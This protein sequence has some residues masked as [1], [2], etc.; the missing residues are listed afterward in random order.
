MT[1]EI[2]CTL[3][4]AE[5]SRRER[6]TRA[7]VER[8]LGTAERTREGVRIRLRDD[9]GVAEEVEELVARE[10]Q[11]CGFLEFAVE[12]R[13]GEVVVEVAGPPE[14][15]HLFDCAAEAARR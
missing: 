1:K 13:R 5:R 2:A 8:A 6:E 15:G 14:A 3:G 12:R 11:C 10:R 4:A 9:P 7:L